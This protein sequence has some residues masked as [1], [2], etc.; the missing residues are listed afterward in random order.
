M[1]YSKI[2]ILLG[3]GCL[4]GF[5]F[6]FGIGKQWGN[7]AKIESVK[8]KR[9]LLNAR[10][11][12]LVDEDQELNQISNRESK[13]E[14]M[15]GNAGFYQVIV[16]NSIFRPLG[17][18]PP[19]EEPE[20]RLLGTAIGINSEAFVVENRSNRFYVVSIGDEIGD[21][22]IKEIE[23]KRVI[24]NKNG[25][26][27]TLNTGGIEFLK[28]GGS[29]SRNTSSSQYERENEKD[30]SNQKG[31]RSKLTELDAMKKR[32]AKITKESEKQIKNVMKEVSKV[33][34]GLEKEEYKM[35]MEKKK[36]IAYDLKLKSDK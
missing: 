34:K 23:E 14:K 4:I 17:W 28:T 9:N 25:E 33:E 3:I 30:S 12:R 36:T 35:L 15:N 11:K 1:K 29:A 2:L 8:E 27:I 18:K 7:L 21:A 10:V 22:V 5:L 6:V 26:T 32:Y 19:N 16:E 20:Y 31:T 13:N 24:L